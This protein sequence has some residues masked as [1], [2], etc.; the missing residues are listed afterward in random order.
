M[1]GKVLSF[2]QRDALRLD[3]ADRRDQALQALEQAVNKAIA[4]L[5]A[6]RQALEAEALRA[7]I[8]DLRHL[9]RAEDRLAMEEYGLCRDCRGVL[10]FHQ[11]TADPLATQCVSCQQKKP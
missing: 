7:G 5:A 4:L 8:E 10:A 2:K 11:L 6:S 1:A 3:V 9:H